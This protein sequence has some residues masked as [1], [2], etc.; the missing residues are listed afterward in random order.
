MGPGA[1]TKPIGRSELRRL[2]KL[3]SY[4]LGTLAPQGIGR[5]AAP[6]QF[7]PVFGRARRT[8]SGSAWVLLTVAGVAGIGGAALIGLWFV[9]LIAGILTGI[10]ARFA[11]VRLRGA[12]LT[13]LFMCGAGWGGALIFYSVRGQPVGA[14]ARVIAAVAGLPAYAAV[15]IAG[16]LAVSMLLGLTGLWLGRALTPRPGR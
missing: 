10:C 6:R 9:P 15:A 7:R 16:T 13:V 11:E 8:G 2:G 4:R 5:P 12:V 3:G 1:M 14:T